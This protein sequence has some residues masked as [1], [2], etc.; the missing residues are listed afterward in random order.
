MLPGPNTEPGPMR[1][2]LPSFCGFPSTRW[3]LVMCDVEAIRPRMPLDSLGE[4][5][6]F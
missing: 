3:S 6:C 4:I 2:N 1:D 5:P